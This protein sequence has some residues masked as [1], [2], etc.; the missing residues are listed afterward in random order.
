MLLTPESAVIILRKAGCEQV[1]VL[2]RFVGLF[3]FFEHQ[4]SAQVWHIRRR[5]YV[6]NFERDVQAAFTMSERRAA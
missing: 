1:S 3:A 5:A 4:G 6:T 2:T